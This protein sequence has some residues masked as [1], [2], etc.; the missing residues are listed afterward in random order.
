[1]HENVDITRELQESKKLLNNILLVEGSSH[2]KG[3][4][5]TETQLLDV[6]AD[7]LAKVVACFITLCIIVF[8]IYL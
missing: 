6:A 4:E 8:Y 3:G 2:S 7:I 1:M 5:S